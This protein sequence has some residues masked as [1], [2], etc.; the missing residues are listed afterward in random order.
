MIGTQ[1]AAIVAITALVRIIFV[2][3]DPLFP[4]RGDIR[5]ESPRFLA[6]A[7]SNERHSTTRGKPQVR[8]DVATPVTGPNGRT[9]PLLICAGIFARA[10]RAIPEICR[11]PKSIDVR[12]R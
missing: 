10:F 3:V 4:N 9:I 8:F 12:R 6:D 11:R 7:R 1:A 2:I 5:A